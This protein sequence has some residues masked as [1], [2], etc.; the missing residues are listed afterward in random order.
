METPARTLDPRLRVGYLVASAVGVFFLRSPV[1]VAPLLALQVVLWLVVG[2]GPRRLVRQVVKLWA[3]VAF[4]VIS[5]AVT[6]ES[7]EVDRWIVIQRLFGLKINVGGALVG[8]TMVMRV[9][10]V[11]LAS[12]VARAGDERAIATGLKKLG[13]PLAFSA[14]VDATLAL[15]R[16][17]RYKNSFIFKYSPRPGTIAYDKMEDDV[18]EDVKRRRNNELLAIQGEISE[19][20]HRQQIGR[21]VEVFVEGVSKQQRKR[22]GETRRQRAVQLA[23]HGATFLH[24]FA[25]QTRGSFLFQAAKEC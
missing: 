25:N 10:S 7:P 12:Q 14:T 1:A 6:S 8:L 21:E 16:R 4:I 24:S 20:I 5:Y 2:L 18:A 13:L 9:V 22:D 3:F 15:L 23:Q 11:V 19:E 17:A